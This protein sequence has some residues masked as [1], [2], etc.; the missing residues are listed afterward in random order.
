MYGITHSSLVYSLIQKQ[1]LQNLK[2][3]HVRRSLH[4]TQ[5]WWT[6]SLIVFHGYSSNSNNPALI[7]YKCIEYI[8]HVSSWW[9]VSRSLICCSKAKPLL[10]VLL[11]TIILM[12]YYF[13]LLNCFVYKMPESSETFARAM[14]WECLFLALPVYRISQVHSIAIKLPCCSFFPPNIFQ[15]GLIQ[16]DTLGMATMV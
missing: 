6:G 1:L 10:V 8:L 7:S 14:T 13:F 3:C 15:S 5:S 12:T 4:V 11:L 16:P 9:H 2:A